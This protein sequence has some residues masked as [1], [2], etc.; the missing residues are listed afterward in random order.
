M[1]AADEDARRRLA[2]FYSALVMLLGL[3]ILGATAMLAMVFG[4]RGLLNVNYLSFVIVPAFAALALVVFIKRQQGWAMIAALLLAIYTRIVFGGDSLF[5]NIALTT[6]VM[7]F[8]ALTVLCLRQPRA[9]GN[10][11]GS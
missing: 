11:A 3:G 6:A 5:L 10:S 9:G 8:V 7:A 1:R 2:Q 4:P